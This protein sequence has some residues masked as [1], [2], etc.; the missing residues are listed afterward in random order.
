MDKK[1]L[2]NE[3]KQREITGGI[4]RITN[5]QNGMYLLDYSTNI[6]AKQNSFNFMVSSGNCIN[7]RLKKDWEAFGAGAFT[8]ETLETIVK[9]KEQSQEQFTEDL[10]IL[11]QIWADKLE[12]SARYQ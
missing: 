7:Y 11:R 6:G 1:S 2:I 5:T 12:V 9:K 3:Y 8:F 10:E 4:Y